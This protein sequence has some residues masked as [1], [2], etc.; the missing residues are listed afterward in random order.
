MIHNFVEVSQVCHYTSSLVFSDI[1][2]KVAHKIYGIPQTINTANYVFFLAYKE[3]F[4]LRNRGTETTPDKDL[5]AIVTGT[6]CS[7]ILAS[8]G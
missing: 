2:F 3:L 1:T 4:A 7:T 5:D 6:L 8:R